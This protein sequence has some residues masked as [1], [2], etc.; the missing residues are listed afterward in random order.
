MYLNT[1]VSPYNP[2]RNLRPR[3]KNTLS[4]PETKLKTYGDRAFT[5]AGPAVWNALPAH[6]RS[7][8][9]FEVFKRDLK[10]FLF[11]KYFNVS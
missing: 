10:T 2:P 4:V 8:R 1:L 11:S 7:A 9:D 3:K 5:S 6:L